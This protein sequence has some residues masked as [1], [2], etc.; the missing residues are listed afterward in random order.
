MSPERNGVA[1]HGKMLSGVFSAT[2]EFLR[3]KV[4]WQGRPLKRE[5]GGASTPNRV[6]RGRGFFQDLQPLWGDDGLYVR[7]S[8]HVSAA[9]FRGFAERCMAEYDL[10]GW[11]APDLITPADINHFLKK[12]R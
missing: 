12:P 3:V 11:T 1:D 4:P 9:Q 7:Q 5:K 2:M 10:D 8:R 6:A